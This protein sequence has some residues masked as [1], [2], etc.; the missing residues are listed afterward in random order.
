MVHHAHWRC[1][2]LLELRIVQ[3]KRCKQDRLPVAQTQL[4]NLYYIR[5]VVVAS[6]GV[7][8]FVLCRIAWK[9]APLLIL[10]AGGRVTA[11]FSGMEQKYLC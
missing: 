4:T 10:H 5:I 9:R 11:C 3:P 6:Q 2:I 7:K 1:S 8:V